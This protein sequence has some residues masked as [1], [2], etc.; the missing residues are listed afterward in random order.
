MRLRIHINR[1]NLPEWDELGSLDWTQP[2]A[3]R[4]SRLARNIGTTSDAFQRRMR[5]IRDLAMRG[6][7][8]TSWLQTRR[9]AR[10][11]SILWNENDL[12]LRKTPPTKKTLDTLSSLFVSPSQQV[13]VNLL[14]L[15]LREYDH[16]EDLPALRATLQKMMQGLDN[17]LFYGDYSKILKHQTIIIAK[18][19]PR[20]LARFALSKHQDFEQSCHE[21]GLSI[22]RDGRFFQLSKQKYFLETISTLKVGAKSHIF[23]EVLS[24]SVKISPSERQGEYFGHDVIRA[25]IDRVQAAK[26]VMP[27]L[28]IKIVLRLAGDPRMPKGSANY[29]NW[30]S[31][32]EGKYRDLMLRW[33]SRYDLRL[34]LQILEESSNTADMRRMFPSRRRF[35]EGLDESGLVLESR[36][37]L[38]HTAR[39]SVRRT[40]KKRDLPYF[41]D[42]SDS[43]TSVIYLRLTKCHIVEGTHNYSLWIYDQMPLRNPVDRPK[44]SGLYSRDLGMGMKEQYEHERGPRGNDQPPFRI[45]HNPNVTW[46]NTG[47]RSMNQLGVRVDPERVLSAE[48]Y[49]EYLRRFGA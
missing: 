8:L 4:T 17:N 10:I 36:L 20:D 32:L 6:E 13:F 47:I 30:W 34:F 22:S 19:A 26:T 5:E 11:V 9:D 7:S 21:C 31:A 29:N 25:M 37:F 48:D 43:E 28:W 45:R 3:A 38:S 41:E 24:N 12:F 1:P 23:K 33:L 14:D 35:L 16:L 40:V 39:R 46:Q 2:L 44:F 49:R 42:L 27:D 15:Y 18:N